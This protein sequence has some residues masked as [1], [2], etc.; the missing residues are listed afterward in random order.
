MQVLNVE[1]IQEVSG[2]VQDKVV[3]AAF[4]SAGGYLGSYLSAARFGATLGA[5]AG[6]IGAIV[7]GVAAG[8]F[9]YYYYDQK[10]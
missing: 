7:G 5:A 3:P 9:V 1:E 8:V 10:R 2:G 6:P 4:I